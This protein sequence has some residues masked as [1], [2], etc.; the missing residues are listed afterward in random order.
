MRTVGRKKGFVWSH[1]VTHE[2]GRVSCM[3]CGEPIKINFGEK[4]PLHLGYCSA[5]ELELSYDALA[6]LG[7]ASPQALHKELHQEPFPE[8]QQGVRGADRVLQFADC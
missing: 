7:R 3:H 4:V 6:V 1:V 8:G 5:L 2:D